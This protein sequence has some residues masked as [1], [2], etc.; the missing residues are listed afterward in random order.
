MFKDAIDETVTAGSIA[1]EPFEMLPLKK[2][3]RVIG[4]RELFN[5]IEYDASGLGVRFSNLGKPLFRL[6]GIKNLK[7]A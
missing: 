3:V 1:L 7:Q 4:L 2:G 5:V 6:S